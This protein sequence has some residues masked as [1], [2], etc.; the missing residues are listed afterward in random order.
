MAIFADSWRKYTALGWAQFVLARHDKVPAIAG[1]GGFKSA[2]T[3]SAALA[4]WALDFPHANIGIATG[5]VSG[6]IV[7]DK[8]PRNGSEET[9]ARLAKQGKRLP[10]TVESETCQGGR[11]LYFTYDPRVASGGCNKLG[12]GLDV[13]TDGGYVVAPPSYVTKRIEKPGAYRWIRPPRGNALPA[14]P[15]WVFE[16]LMPKPLSRRQ[17]VPLPSP[18]DVEGYRRQALADLHDLKHL[19]SEMTD[20]RHQ[21]PFSKAC[22]IGKYQAHG[23]LT[24]AEI[25]GAFLDA[26][27]ANGALSKYAVKD[28]VSQIRNGLR[29]AQADGL[30]PLA[31]IHR[32]VQ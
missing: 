14:L 32:R 31:R 10:D 7:I 29:R 21:A 15:G 26:S 16:A 19:M 4:A 2:T 22:V 1:A 6:I 3:D 27:A 24:E 23:F 13:R 28:L 18:R 12:P 9:I 30:P 25:E 20:G 8:D 11:H 17:P 5:R